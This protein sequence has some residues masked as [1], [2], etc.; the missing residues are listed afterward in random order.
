M[1]KLTLVIAGFLA[2]RSVKTL[3]AFSIVS[4]WMVMGR[5]LPGKALN[6]GMK[7]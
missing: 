2:S 3:S 1:S 7:V 4:S 6:S 5:G